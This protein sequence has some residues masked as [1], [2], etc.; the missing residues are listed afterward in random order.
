MKIIPFL[1]SAVTMISIKYIALIFGII[2]CFFSSKIPRNALAKILCGYIGISLGSLMG[3]VLF[4]NV[5]AML[6]FTLLP[7]M[8]VSIILYFVQR[9]IRKYDK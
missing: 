2:L 1:N 6:I 7:I 3:Y 5:I 8:G 9:Q 4:K